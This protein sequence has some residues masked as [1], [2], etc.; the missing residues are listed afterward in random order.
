MVVAAD[1]A[2]DIW[3][4]TIGVATVGVG[5]VDKVRFTGKEGLVGM[6]LCNYSHFEP[7]FHWCFGSLLLLCLPQYWGLPW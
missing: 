1:V 6:G 2:T 5:S 3:V 7:S 4:V